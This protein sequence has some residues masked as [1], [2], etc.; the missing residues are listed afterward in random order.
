MN[1]ETGER[2]EYED[3][4]GITLTGD[5]LLCAGLFQLINCFIRKSLICF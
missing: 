5:A 2:E 1:E 4:S 3:L